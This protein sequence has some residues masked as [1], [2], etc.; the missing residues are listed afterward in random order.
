MSSSHIISA[1]LLSPSDPNQKIAC[2][3]GGCGSCA[4]I[5]SRKAT[6]ATSLNQDICLAVNSCLRPLASLHGWNVTTVEG[7]RDQQQGAAVQTRISRFNGSQCGFCTPGM[8]VSLCAQLHKDDGDGCNSTDNPSS[9]TSTITK[10]SLARSLDGNLCRCTG[11]RPILDAAV[12]FLPAAADLGDLEDMM[13]KLECLAMRRGKSEDKKIRCDVG[14]GAGAVA[15]VDLMDA[16]SSSPSY[17]VFE[18]TGGDRWYQPQDLAEL[19]HVLSW[20]PEAC[21]I[22]GNTGRSGVYKQDKEMDEAAATA[23]AVNTPVALVSFQDVRELHGYIWEVKT[24]WLEV[25]AGLTLSELVDV[26]KG[27]PETAFSSSILRDALLAHLHRVA[28]T[29]VRN[30]G[31]LGGNLYI[32]KSKHFDSDLS[33]LMGGLG[34][35]VRVAWGP[36]WAEKELPWLD[37]LN[38]NEDEDGTEEEAR[39]R[40]DILLRVRFRLW[41]P[42]ARGKVDVFQSYRAALRKG[43]SHAFANA[44]FRAN[45]DSVTGR[46]ENVSLCMGALGMP[47]L[48]SKDAEEALISASADSVSAGTDPLGQASLEA[49]LLAL[50][51]ELIPANKTRYRYRVELLSGFLYKFFLYLKCQVVSSASSPSLDVRLL[52]AATVPDV[53]VALKSSEQTYTRRW[54]TK[55]GEASSSDSSTIDYD[56]L[57]YVAL[58]K[59]YQGFQAS[60]QAV[61]VSDVL[62]LEGTLFGAYAKSP[63]SVGVLTELQVS[64]AK[65][66]PGV[67][68]VLTAADVPGT[69][70]C[71]FYFGSPDVAAPDTVF[72]PLGGRV[73]FHSQPLALVVATSTKKAQMA[74]KL[75]EAVFDGFEVPLVTISDAREAGSSMGIVDGV[76]RGDAM[77]VLSRA[78]LEHQKGLAANAIGGLGKSLSVV[79]GALRAGSQK[80]FYLETQTAYAVPDEGRMLV[81]SSTQAP[82]A[83]QEVVAR[84]LGTAMNTVQVK[85]RRAGGAFGAKATRNLPHAAAAAVAAK[86]LARPVRLTLDR[87]TDMQ[88][89]G[90]RHAMEAEYAVA[91]DPVT[92]LVE[93]VACQIWLN[94]GFCADLSFTPCHD[95]AANLEQA[96]FIPH[97]DASIEVL[98]T[99]LPTST[100]MRGPGVVQASFIMESILNHVAAEL[101]GHLTPEEVRRVNFFRPVGEGTDAAPTTMMSAGCM[102][103]PPTPISHFTLPDIWQRLSASAQLEAR[104]KEVA[105]FNEANRW[106]K[107]GMAMT[108]IKFLSALMPMQATV[109]AYSDGSIL[110]HHGG[111]EIGQGIHAKSALVALRALAQI[112]VVEPPTLSMVQF[113]DTDTDV[114]P[115]GGYTAAS[116]T[117]ERACAAVD[118]ACRVMV[119]RLAPLR[120]RLMQEKEN[121]AKAAAAACAC[122]ATEGNNGGH[123]GGPAVPAP[124]TWVELVKTALGFR[125][126][127]DLCCHAQWRPGLPGHYHNYGAALTEVEVDVLTGEVTIRA[128]HLLYDCGKSINPAADLGQVEGAFV[129][130]LGYYLMEEALIATDGA[131][132]SPGTWDYKPPLLA[133]MPAEW[134]VG[135]LE[136]GKFEKGFL[137]SKASGEPPLVLA[138]S[139]MMALRHAVTAA[140]KEIFGSGS[141]AVHNFRL[142]APATPERVHRACGATM[143]C[144][145]LH[146]AAGAQPWLDETPRHHVDVAV[147]GAGLGGLALAIALDKLGVNAALFE[148]APALRDVSQGLVGI[149]PNGLR[150]LELID[151]RLKEHLMERGKYNTEA[152]TKTVDEQGQ[153]TERVVQFEANNVSIPWADI[154]HSL[155]RLVPRTMIKCSH[156]FAGF[157]ED[158]DGVTIYFKG[159]VETARTVMLVGVDGLFSVVRKGLVPFPDGRGDEV[160]ESGHTNWNAI[161]KPDEAGLPYPHPVV[162]LTYLKEVPPRFFFMIQCGHG[163]ILWQVRVSDPGKEYTVAPKKG[164]GRLGLTGVKQR[165]LD[166]VA[167]VPDVQPYIA[168]TPEET[169]FERC[170]LFRKPLQRYSTPGRHVVLMG[171]AAHAMHSV[172]GQGANMTFEDAHCLGLA[173]AAKGVGPAAVRVFERARIPRANLVQWESNTYYMRQFEKNT[174][175]TWALKFLNFQSYVADFHKH[176][177]L[178][179]HL[180]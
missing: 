107:R 7:L 38:G 157:D 175:H 176:E 81:Y 85:M 64:A 141:A 35:M 112:G 162:S 77:A 130:G 78:R 79:E 65:A 178:P 25:G 133:D 41:D 62:E 144:L 3:E 128:V 66:M 54:M 160:C 69:N 98:R 84:V 68:A 74:A 155:A 33:T 46:L 56:H 110:I 153:S 119:K 116:T 148:R 94:G 122:G 45:I 57:P 154:Q 91:Y 15:S 95:L 163:R 55:D 131:L 17:L 18:G 106:R 104:R 71:A 50:R 102:H 31:S 109:N 53:P 89:T 152:F 146:G 4:V 63:R 129:Q 86:V 83:V 108:P 6:N 177:A 87:A 34:A 125:D 150:A 21:L 37:Y 156:D 88:L 136:N 36:G 24:G 75:V 123:G 164:H 120:D 117:S 52:S 92:G 126:S 42:R 5:V 168:A 113:A 30:A 124:L 137:S 11:Y 121:K 159:R 47:A 111:C 99:N 165:I 103:M 180:L 58:P 172:R 114:I 10:E 44:A 22:A 93:A 101:A 171:D 127:I 59:D 43:N 19:F 149:T 8:V 145:S 158:E 48:R 80:H 23:A 60:G 40:R 173:L 151:P 167:D 135:L 132:Q 143:G 179:A 97:F 169:I 134:K 166:M 73:R 70:D 49:A 90:G 67:V 2:G 96:Y 9:L 138:T 174:S 28:G 139:A 27:L 32:A 72:V 14:S 140:R 12:S 118:A 16:P 1:S 13:G 61:Y 170:L 161:M 39:P 100:A 82:Q 142:D 29:L 20:H 76:K 147:A 26:L 105:A 51:K 115:N